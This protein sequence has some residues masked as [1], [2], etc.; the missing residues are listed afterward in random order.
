MTPLTPNASFSMTLRLQVPNRSEILIKLTEGIAETGAELGDLILVEK[1]AEHSIRVLTFAASSEDHAQ[2]VL[3][4]L[5]DLP[6][7]QVLAAEDRTFALHQGGKISVES[8]SPLKNQ[9]QLSRGYTPGVGRVCQAI[10]QNPELAFTYTIK[11][12]T[13]AIVTDGSAVLGLGNIGPLAALPVMEGKAMIFKEFAGL[14]AFPVC[15]DTQDTEAIIATVQ[16]LAPVFGGINLEDISSP[17][18]F[19]IEERLRDLLDIPVFHDDQHGT[20]VVLLAALL[21][22]LAI[23]EKPLAEIKVVFN[24][25]GAAGMACTQMLQQAGVR[26]IVGCDR[27]GA[28]YL[29]RTANMNSVKERYAQITNPQGEQGSLGD[30]LRGADVFVGL[31]GPGLVTLEDIQGMATKPLVFALANPVPEIAPEVA[32]PHVAVMA[33]GRSD[34]PN[35]INNALAY[36][37]IFKGALDCRARCI[38]EVMKQAAAQALAGLILPAE[39]RPGYIIPSVFDPRVVPAVAQ[40][41][42]QAARETGVARLP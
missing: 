17:R 42:A 38:N 22:A 34:Y 3:A 39:R 35:Q 20:A 23:V 15:L 12:H 1:L 30:V 24:G 4:V 5:K 37:G 40:A 25:V 10:H 18:C 11:P 28:I 31:S 27:S 32:G 8:K 13:V 29:G 14:D 21:N 16:Y 41:V 36:P 2:W 9:D 33:T 26:H 19:E 7:V 6:G